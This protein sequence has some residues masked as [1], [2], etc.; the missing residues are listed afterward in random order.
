MENDQPQPV[1]ELT[2]DEKRIQT[3]KILVMNL[4]SAKRQEESTRANRIA[5]EETIAKLIPGKEIGQVTETLPDRSKVVV[6]RGFNYKADL[7]D[8]ERALMKFATPAPIESKTTRSLD[9]KG[10]EWYRKHQPEIF[11]EIVK[12]VTVTPKKVSVVLKPAKEN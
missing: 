7:D 6:T 10:Y 8:I 12:H 5:V 2:P 9:I 11:T 4:H 1:E 3:L